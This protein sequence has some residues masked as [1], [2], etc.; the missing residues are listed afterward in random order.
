MNKRTFWCLLLSSC[1]VSPALAQLAQQET[2]SSQAEPG[3]EEMVR[4]V[5]IVTRAKTRTAVSQNE[6]MAID[7]GLVDVPGAPPKLTEGVTAKA[8]ARYVNYEDSLIAQLVLTGVEKDGR[9]EPLDSNDFVAQFNMDSPELDP[10]SPVT[11]EGNQETLIA[12]LQRLNDVEEKDDK[13]EKET[14]AAEADT[15]ASNSVGSNASKNADAA[16]Y[17]TPSALDVKESASPTV[18]LTTEGCNI[19]V[20]IPALTAYQQSRVETNEDGN[21]TYSECADGA[22]NFKISQSYAVCAYDEDVE[23]MTATAQ[24]MYFYTDG[25]GNRQEIGDCQ[26]DAEKVYDIVEDRSA[27][28]VYLDYGSLLA[29]PQGKLVYTNHNNKTVPVADCAASIEIAPAPMTQSTEGCDIRDDFLAGKSYSRSKYT[30]TLEGKDW[31]TA[32][33]DDGTEFVHSTVYKTAAGDQVCEPIINRESGK[34]TLQSRV[35]INVNGFELYRTPC[36]PDSGTKDIVE[37]TAGCED[38]SKWTHNISASQSYGS[39]RYYYM[40]DGKQEPVTECQDSDVI[41]AHQQE[42][43]GY[44][45]HDDKLFSYRLVTLYIEGT[46][47]GRYNIATSQVLAGDP[48]IPYS[49]EGQSPKTNGEVFFEECTRFEG[50]DLVNAYKRPDGTTYSLKVDDAT[51]VNQGNDCI[52]EHVWFPDQATYTVGAAFTAYGER[53]ECWWIRNEPV[54]RRTVRRTDTA[55]VNTVRKV[56]QQEGQR[57]RENDVWTQNHSYCV[58]QM[59]WRKNDPYWPSSISNSTKSFWYG[60]WGWE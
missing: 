17:S 35:M 38:P 40:L 48:Q 59:S 34:V 18:R 33:S 24:F 10:A 3:I 31:D 41:Y 30:Y 56:G 15:G 5:N 57:Y 13:E 50:R 1:L 6:P 42:T 9:S 12:A 2:T 44:Q 8:Y 16:G 23:A 37:T 26:P 55:I 7:L 21:I 43:T 51:P 22:E 60:Q 49:Y 36:T 14:E 47:Q 28:N 53:A 39:V 54:E 32:C 29:V 4:K 19:R 11:I 20:D 45:N 46:P 52:T 27:C 25:G 58:S